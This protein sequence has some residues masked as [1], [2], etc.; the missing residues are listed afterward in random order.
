MKSVPFVDCTAVEKKL[1]SAYKL[2]LRNW[3]KWTNY[4]WS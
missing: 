2:K 1:F 4:I 3:I